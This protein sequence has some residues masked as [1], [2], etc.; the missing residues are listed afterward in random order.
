MREVKVHNSRQ[1]SK[2]LMNRGL[3]VLEL[4]KAQRYRG[5]S[6]SVVI[7]VEVVAD[8]VN[9]APDVHLCHGSNYDAKL[10]SLW[11]PASSRRC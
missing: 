1:R 3:Q 4:R 5:G 2:S 9:C 8:R 6:D 10:E 7:P 11:S